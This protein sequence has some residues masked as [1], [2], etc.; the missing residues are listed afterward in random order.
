MGVEIK[1]VKM[2]QMRYQVVPLKKAL[3]NASFAQCMQN[4]SDHDITYMDIPS[5]RSII[6]F[7]WDTYVFTFF[8]VWFGVLCVF[9]ALVLGD[10]LHCNSLHP[11]DVNLSKC[12]LGYRIPCLCIL[13]S[14]TVYELFQLAR[15]SSSRRVFNRDKFLSYITSFWSIVD[16]AL[17][18]TYVA[19][20]VCDL[21]G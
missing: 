13:A 21:Y 8:A 10:I 12:R 17:I 20:F 1:Q 4:A 14:F 3:E 16:A 19:Y 5:V 6:D 9:V 11:N 15:S 2:Y 18:S 7:K